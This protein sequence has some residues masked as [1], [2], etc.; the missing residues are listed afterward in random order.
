MPS[1][2]RQLTRLSKKRLG[3]RAQYRVVD[4]F[5]RITELVYVSCQVIPNNASIYFILRGHMTRFFTVLA[6]QGPNV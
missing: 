2:A 1:K 4:T 6:E 5:D 3:A